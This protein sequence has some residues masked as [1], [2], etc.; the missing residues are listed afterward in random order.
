ML[1]YATACT[2][3]HN[4]PYLLKS[5][6]STSWATMVTPPYDTLLAFGTTN[7]AQ[8]A[9]ALSLMTFKYIGKEH[10]NH[11][12]QCLHN[13]YQEVD[14]DWEGKCFCGVHLK[15]D[16]AHCTCD[17]SMPGYIKN[18]L[19]KFQHPTPKKTPDNPYPTTAKQY[20]MKVQ[21]TDP[22]NTSTPLPLHEVKCLQQIIGTFLF[23][24]CAV[25]PTIL[26]ALSELSSNQATAMEATKH[27]CHQFLD[28][29][30]SNPDGSICYHASDMVL[31]L[32]SNSSYLN[33]IR[34]CSQQGGH[35]YLGN[36]SDPDIL[37]GTILNLT[38][39]MKMVLSSAAE[40]EFGALFHN[41]KEAIPL[42]TTLKEL[43]HPQPPTLT[44]IDN[45]TTV[46]LANDTAPSTCIFSGYV[47][48]HINQK[49]FHVY[50]APTHLN[51]I[52][53]FTKHH[54]HHPTTEPCASTSST[55]QLAQSTFHQCQNMPYCGG[56]LIP[57]QWLSNG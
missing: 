47:T 56:V 1:K 21:L 20:G 50:W 14:I 34:A 54:T 49:Q 6:S 5:S 32:H 7:G 30:A 35:F 29:C 27:A 48:D 8:S 2:A 44:L 57:N 42:C 23:Y 10:A 39:I 55:P 36:K 46:G 25:D 28:Y 52:D 38:A 15:W 31:K 51:L 3:F 11:L 18:S 53:Y 33:A 45:S 4:L 19:H 12:I 24:G 17:P 37:N 13:H 26:T 41:T 43:G 9:S 16:Y 22:I 40:A